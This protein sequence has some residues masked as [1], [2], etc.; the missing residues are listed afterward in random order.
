MRSKP[1][2]WP[3]R[4]ADGV[5]KS[6]VT[7]G[8]KSS[9]DPNNVKYSLL[10]TSFLL[11]SANALGSFPLAVVPSWT[12]RRCSRAFV[13][14][15][16]LAAASSLSL[17]EAA[18][19]GKLMVDSASRTL[20]NGLTGLG[21][22]YLSAKVGAIFFDPSFP[23]HYKIVTQVPAAQLAAAT[24]IGLTLRPDTPATAKK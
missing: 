16:L 14:W 18:E 9:D 11:L 4:I 10:S 24:M 20:S 12:G 3:G 5:A 8:P 17:K 2:T 6:L 1:L 22:V 7:L 13:A 23:V 19:S 15:T 21:A